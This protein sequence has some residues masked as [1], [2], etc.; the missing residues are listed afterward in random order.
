MNKKISIILLNY[1]GKQFNKKC[2]DS[3]LLQSY[4]DFEIIFVD[5]VSTDGSLEEVEKTYE[6][7]IKIKKII[8][9]KN[10]EN[11]GFTGG[12]NLGVKYAS[13]K[14]EYICLLNND[15]TVPKNWLEELIKGIESD[16]E[17]GA[18]GSV[19]LDKGYEEEIKNTHFKNKDVFVSTILGENA[20]EKSII[21]NGIMYTN[22]ISGCCVLY[23]KNIIK[24]PF[25]EF[26][27]GYGEDIWLGLYLLITGYKLA[28]CPKSIVNHFGSGSFGKKPS[29][30]KLFYGNRNQIIN[31]LVFYK[32]TTIIKLFPLF[33]INQ[34]SHLFLDVPLK[35]IKAK[36]KSWI[37][38]FN[39]R[40]K[41]TSL[42]NLIQKDRILSDK[43]MIYIL[44]HK[45]SDNIFYVK[46]NRIKLLLIK[47][48]NYIFRLYI[49]LFFGIF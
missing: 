48:A 28:I 21:K 36:I 30:L 43:N 9:I 22:V 35:R 18:V 4:Q 25:P 37:W 1:N 39:N 8:I 29:D 5:N 33:I 40:K 10:K 11:T 13:K 26:Y 3:I 49:K 31:F 16:G 41:I 2:I 24:K 42:K 23:K 34:M 44:S 46:F 12:N 15:T 17:L 27:F 6:E 38:I 47:T 14:S 20:I 32:I 7:E 45:L 19:I